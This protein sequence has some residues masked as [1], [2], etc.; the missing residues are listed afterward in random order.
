[1]HAIAHPLN[2]L[3]GVENSNAFGSARDYVPSGFTF[4]TAFSCHLL[5]HATCLQITLKRYHLLMIADL[6]LHCGTRIIQI[7][8]TTLK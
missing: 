5:I 8:L 7:T 1:M 3:N 4:N 2:K 6:L